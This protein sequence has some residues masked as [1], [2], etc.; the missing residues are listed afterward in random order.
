MLA[1]GAV[2]GISSTDPYIKNRCP[3]A[4]TGFPGPFEDIAAVDGSSLAAEQVALCTS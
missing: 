2:V 3:A 4:W 1:V